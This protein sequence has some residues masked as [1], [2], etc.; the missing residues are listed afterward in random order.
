MNKQ[1]EK[2][3]ISDQNFSHRQ[4]FTFVRVVTAARGIS[5]DTRGA[6]ALPQAG[7]NHR[8]IIIIIL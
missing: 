1:Q 2:V 6:A 3:N 7:Y 5:A 4:G 8:D